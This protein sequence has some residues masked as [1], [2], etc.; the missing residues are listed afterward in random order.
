LNK[1]LGQ[2]K[3]IKTRDEAMKRAGISSK[4]NTAG[5]YFMIETTDNDQNSLGFTLKY[6]LKS[7]KIKD[8]ER[9]VGTFYYRIKSGY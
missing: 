7:E 5:K 6:E 2:N 1:S 9:L 3:N 8:D 4:R